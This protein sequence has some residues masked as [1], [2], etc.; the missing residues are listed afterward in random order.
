MLH[1]FK[2]QLTYPENVISMILSL[3]LHIKKVVKN[4]KITRKSGPLDTTGNLKEKITVKKWLKSVKQFSGNRVQKNWKKQ[5][6][7]VQNQ[8]DNIKCKHLCKKWL[9]SVEQFLRYRVH[10]KGKNNKKQ[11]KIKK[12]GTKDLNQCFPR[13]RLQFLLNRKLSIHF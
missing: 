6:E 10:K 9:E 4:Y 11:Y 12:V 5:E 8:L 2:L 3:S 7:R 13:V 1:N